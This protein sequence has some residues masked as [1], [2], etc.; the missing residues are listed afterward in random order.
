MEGPSGFVTATR[1][2]IRILH[3]NSDEDPDSAWCS[4]L[5]WRLVCLQSPV[6]INKL[7][8]YYLCWW[9]EYIYLFY[10]SEPFSAPKIDLHVSN[11]L[12]S[13][14][15]VYRL[16]PNSQDLTWPWP[17]LYRGPRIPLDW[18]CVPPLQLLSY[19]QIL[20]LLNVIYIYKRDIKLWICYFLC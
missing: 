12:G 9:R 7:E 2:P 13:R 17:I 11:S 20:L 8:L 4:L 14:L 3:C 19:V 5:Y 1:I 16:V 10:V 18:R 6:S 15:S